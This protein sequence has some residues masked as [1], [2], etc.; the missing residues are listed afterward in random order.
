MQ[1]IRIANKS[2]GILP[3]LVQRAVS[4]TGD[5]AIPGHYCTEQQVWV[6]GGVP[7]VASGTSLPELSTKTEANIERD[8]VAPRVILEMQ[9]KTN[10]QL[11]RDDQVRPFISTSQMIFGS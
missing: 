1:N 9:T 5:T 7:L 2:L 6:V 10:A 3:L 8:D 11:E 4:R